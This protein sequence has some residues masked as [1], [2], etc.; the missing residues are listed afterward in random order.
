MGAKDLVKRAPLVRSA[1]DLLARARRRRR[2][3]A[4]AMAYLTPRLR[5][6][7]RWLEESREETNFTYDLTELNLR[8]LCAFLEAVTGRPAR[9]ARGVV[10]ELL[11]D[12]DL[13]DHVRRETERSPCAMEADPV[14]RYG[15]RAGWYA[16]VRLLRPRL[17]VETGVDKGLGACVI[18]AALRRNA[19]EG[20]PGRYVGTDLHPDAGWLFC[21]PYA[22]HG[23][24]LRG[25][26]IDSLTRVSGPID[27]FIADSCHEQ[28]YERR[29]YEA[30][31]DQLAPGAVL[32]S[33][34]AHGS[35]ALVDYA[36]DT[37]RRFLF[38]R[39]E[40]RGHWY[41]GAGI[42]VAWTPRD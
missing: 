30:V 23:E 3:R 25:D 5:A 16:L 32:I 39:E 8:H 42:G 37:G 2:R 11:G 33:D 35:P 4:V 10:D 40:P 6:V 9:T 17:V 14:A 20:A 15:R 24:I 1:R 26:S 38:W 41:P 36:A 29:E 31:A 7:D 27:L 22:A 28:G 12:R 13:A 18:A 21:G 19:A 34:T